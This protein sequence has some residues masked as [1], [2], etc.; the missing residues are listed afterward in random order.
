MARS[1]SN[2]IQY[3]NVTKFYA[4]ATRGRDE[5]L[6]SCFS[7]AIELFREKIDRNISSRDLISVYAP[8]RVNL[9]GEHT[10]YNNG[11]VFPM[12]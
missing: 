6:S 2:D 3:E 8:G 9:I 11:C 12:V 7:D 1:R 10:D 4:M 5:C